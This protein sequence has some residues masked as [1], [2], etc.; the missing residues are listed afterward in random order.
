MDRGGGG[1][2]GGAAALAAAPAGP[3]ATVP[4][5]E[6]P[7]YAK[8]FKM[9]KAGVPEGAV[10]LKMGADGLDAEM[11]ATPEALIPLQ[12]DDVAAWQEANPAKAAAAAAPATA[13]PAT[14]AKLVGPPTTVPATEHP[15][16]SKFF[17]MR[18]AG[19]PEGAVRLKMGA[20]GLNAE[21]L[22][23][24]AAHVP[25]TG[26]DIAAWQEVNPGT[27]A[28]GAAAGVAAG[29]VKPAGPPATVP[30]QEHPKYGKFFKM[31]KAGVPEGAVRLKM[32]ADSLNPEMLA[33]PSA[34]VPLTGDDIAAWQEANRGAVAAPASAPAKPADPPSAVPV[35]EHPK[36]AKFFKMRKAGVPEG[37]VRMK[38]GAEGLDVA[39]LDTPNAQVPLTGDDVAAWLEAN[40][41]V[42]AAAALVPAAAP[43]GPPSAVPAKDHPKYA[44]YFK[45]RKAGVP[46]GAVRNKMGAE[47]L[48]AAILETPNAQVP[49]TGDEVAAWLEANPEAAVAAVAAAPVKPTGPPAAVPATA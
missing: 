19:V 23:T 33:T 17:K 48:D 27:V 26:E 7:K 45:M 4:A 16:Y 6:H 15:K 28:A 9:R 46:E 1:G 37:A 11:L 10:R 43:A 29:P 20:D 21:M 31:R 8:F 22:A 2:G 30:A 41:G 38:L 36:Y 13:A 49:L 18:K 25:L 24:P 44:K 42:A 35:Q 3:P 14:S 5:Q 12:G 34:Q 32:G 39:M 40:P 47:S